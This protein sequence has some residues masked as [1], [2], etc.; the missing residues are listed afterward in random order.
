MT[1]L[2]HAQCVPLAV[3]GVYFLKYL[4]LISA[5]VTWPV[6]SVADTLWQSSDRLAQQGPERTTL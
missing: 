1:V 2:S 4:C 5:S 3:S 6:H